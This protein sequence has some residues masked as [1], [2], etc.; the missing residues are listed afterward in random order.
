MQSVKSI[1]HARTLP[2]FAVSLI[3]VGQLK[4]LELSTRYAPSNQYFNGRSRLFI[5]DRHPWD[6]VHITRQVTPEKAADMLLTAG[7]K[8]Y[9][10]QNYP[11]AAA[12]FQ[13][14]LQ[15]FGG[16]PNANA[17]RYGLGLCLIDGPE[18]NFEKAIE[19]LSA[20]AGATTS[21]DHPYALYYLGVA[22]RGAGINDL[23]VAATKQG[24]EQ[25]N[26]RA[27]AEHASMKRPRNLLWR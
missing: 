1:S 17:A 12:K 9:N 23:M 27:G 20:L 7:R 2:P 10:E 19:P 3:A 26:L 8:A 24:D 13:E 14:Y 15:K 16:N 18:R 25:K 5:D 11:F 22:N 6:C 4:P 21:P